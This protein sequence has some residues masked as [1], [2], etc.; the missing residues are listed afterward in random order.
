MTRAAPELSIVI[1]VYNEEQVLPGL[2]ARLYTALDAL[3]RSYETCSSTMAAAIA[4]RRCSRRRSSC[5][6]T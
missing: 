3:G 6:P 5:A 1:P 2:F 4:P